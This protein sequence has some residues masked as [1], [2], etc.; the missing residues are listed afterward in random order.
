MALLVILGPLA[1]VGIA[2]ERMLPSEKPG[3][4]YQGQLRLVQTDMIP[5]KLGSQ[6]VLAVVGTIRNVSEETWSSPQ[7]EVQFKDADGR[8]VDTA[9][10]LAYDRMILPAGE[11]GFKMT[12]APELPLDRYHSWQVVLRSAREGTGMCW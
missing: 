7:V 9:T 5:G 6:P 2:I 10:H 12:L 4:V 8:L 11:I 1:V 3:A